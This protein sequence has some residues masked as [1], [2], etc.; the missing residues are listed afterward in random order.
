MEETTSDVDELVLLQDDDL[1]R[2]QWPLARI[3]KLFPGSDETIRT[4]EIRTHNGVYKRPVTKILKLEDHFDVCQGG[5]NV[6]DD[7]NNMTL[8]QRHRVNY[9]K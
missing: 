1:K 6:T 7:G 8:R 3:T 9:T 5:E 4:V 2:R